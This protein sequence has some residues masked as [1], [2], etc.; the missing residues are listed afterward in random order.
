MVKVY[1]DPWSQSLSRAD[2][3]S[4]LSSSLTWLRYMVPHRVSP[5]LE[6]T[7][8]VNVYGDPWSQTHYI[9]DF[10]SVL[11]PNS[12]MVKVYSH[13]VSPSLQQNSPLSCHPT[14]TWLRCMVMESV[15]LYSRLHLCSVIHASPG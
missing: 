5:S 11:P 15:P 9:T 13:G 6:Q 7:H 2:C 14:L 8:M 10:T 1:G 3:P 12:H 4:I